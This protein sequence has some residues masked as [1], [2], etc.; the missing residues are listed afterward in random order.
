MRQVVHH[1]NHIA[2]TD[3]LSVL[4][5]YNVSSGLKEFFYLFKIMDV[6]FNNQT[7]SVNKDVI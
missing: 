6:T 4:R 2:H 1:P 5:W 7:C 3:K